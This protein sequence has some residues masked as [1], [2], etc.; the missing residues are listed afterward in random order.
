MAKQSHQGNSFTRTF[1][2]L[3]N[4]LYNDVEVSFAIKKGEIATAKAVWD[5]GAMCTVISSDIAKR[6]NLISTSMTTMSSA[7]EKDVPAKEYL[8]NLTLPNGVEISKILVV[9][10]NLSNCEML[11]G[12]NII[13]KGDFSVSN[14]NSHTIFSF[15]MPS[16]TEI[17]F[18]KKS[19][20][21]P[22][23][24]ENKVG[25]ND[26]CPCGS[27]KKYKKCCGSRI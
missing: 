6:L 11:I 18:V 5:T 13:N 16:M 8:V 15:R 2:H 10:G 24:N 9:E 3:S 17:D 25:R 26:P 1:N 4:I 12:M 19:Y 21:E 20:L 23:R 14:M 7:T 27:G 22:I